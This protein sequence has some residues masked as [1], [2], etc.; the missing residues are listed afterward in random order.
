MKVVLHSDFSTVDRSDRNSVFEIFPDTY[1]DSRG[2]FCE[3][4]RCGQSW[5]PGEM[6][7]WFGD[8]SWVRQVNRSSSSPGT[9]R[10]CH[11]QRG[12]HCQGKLVCAVTERIY[13]VITDAR[14]GSET[15]GLSRV[16]LLDSAR[17]NMLWVPRGFLHAFAVPRSCRGN[18]V[19]E[20]WCDNI[21]NKASETGVNPMSV[22]PKAFV[23]APDCDEFSREF[24]GEM[25]PNLSEKDAA[26]ENWGS[27]SDRVMTE[28][29]NT[30]KAW[31]A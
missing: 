19:F 30:G 9:V 28:Y 5:P 2:F 29:E 18:A 14:P 25:S 20:Y 26:A 27:W 10:G 17:Q 1:G 22:L 6:S 13:D 4:F 16:Y 7:S 24:G 21:Y 3:V 8:M 23:T 12:R 31:Y 11:A 15:F